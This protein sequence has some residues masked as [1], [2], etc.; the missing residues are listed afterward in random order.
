MTRI[1]DVSE[2]FALPEAALAGCGVTSVEELWTSIGHEVDTGIEKIIDRTKD[3]AVAEE[4]PA[5]KRVRHSA[6]LAFLIADAL[7]ESTLSYKPKP[8]GL[9]LGVKPLWNALKRFFSVFKRQWQNRAA[10]WT[11]IKAHAFGLDLFW[12]V[13]KWLW[14]QG[15]ETWGNRGDRLWPDL[16]IFGL[17]L[18]FIGLGVRAYLLDRSVVQRVAVKQGATLPKFTVI[19]TQQLITRPVLDESG[20]FASIDDLKQRYLV[21]DVTP[22]ALVKE[23]QLLP[24]NLSWELSAR[25]LLTLP[26]KNEVRKPVQPLERVK[27]ILASR[28]K[29]KPSL[30][31]DDVLLLTTT[32]NGE[33]M[34]VVVAVTDDAVRS[35]APVLGMSDVFVLQVLQPP[36]RAASSSIY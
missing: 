28:E 36:S 3:P 25:H 15:Q 31:I 30:L 19:D 21:R 14:K 18:L 10:T 33:T 24:A 32:K 1:K 29:E 13:P 2:S 27:L 6:L 22:G 26:V 5:A 16:L 9:W 23:D 7:S 4:D 35:I 17:P 20:T 8:L 11:R 12:L 34:S